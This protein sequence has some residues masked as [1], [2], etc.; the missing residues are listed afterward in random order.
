MPP[1][2]LTRPLNPEPGRPALIVLS[3]QGRRG[4][5][6]FAFD[7]HVQLEVKLTPAHVAVVLSLEDAAQEARASGSLKRGVRNPDEL[8]SMYASHVPSA[9]PVIGDTVVH[10][11][12][13]IRR[14]IRA[15]VER[16]NR[17]QGTEFAA[18][19]LIDQFRGV[20]YR[21]DPVGLTIYVQ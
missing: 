13:K 4:I 5:L 7:A 16:L 20:G 11:V 8:G 21:I 2:P 14:R 18:P 6:I 9:K 19:D 1:D 15:A 3:D 17:M 12:W 10:H